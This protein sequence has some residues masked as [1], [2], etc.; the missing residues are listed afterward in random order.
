[1]KDRI[2]LFGI[3]GL[4]WVV[5]FVV[6]RIIFL[7]FHFNLTET[8]SSGEI[9][10]VLFLG[11][12]MDLA[13]AGDWLVLSGI[14][15]M[16]SILITDSNKL[17]YNINNIV[18]ILL[19]IISSLIIVIDLELYRHWG[20][21]LNTT[22]LFYISTEAAGS[23]GAL[24][25]TVLILNFIF[26]TGGFL[27]FYFKKISYRFL[28]LKPVKK[29]WG[30]VMLLLIGSLILPIRSG[31]GV[32]PLNTGMV[33]FHKTKAFPNHAGINVV[34]NFFRS[35]VSKSETRYP[36]NFFDSKKAEENLKQLVRTQ[37]AAPSLLTQEKP[38][39][40]IVVL[41]SFTS[42]IIGPLG[43][44]KDVTPNL[45]A[46]VHEGILFDHFYASGDRTDK[47]IIS[48]LSGYPA[49]PRT[50]IIKYPEKTQSLPYLPKI[51]SKSGYYT[52]FTYGGNIGFANMESY[53]TMAGFNSLTD[54]D[55][56]D[57]KLNSSKW[58]VYDHYVFEHLIH[59]LDTAKTPFF[60][61]L[62]SLSSH[63][64]FDVP[65]DPPFKT[66]NDEMSLFLNA[67]HY[68]DQSLGNFIEQAKTKPW[69]NNTLI[70]I[71]AD[72]GHRLPN[73]Q[74]SSDKERF[75]IPMLW[76]GGAVSKKDTVIHTLS[77]QP[78][79][80]NT[81]LGQFQKTDTTFKFSKNLLAPDAKPFAV[82]VFQNGYGFIDNESE[83]IYD[84]DFNNYIKKESSEE[85]LMLGKAYMQALFSD[86]NNR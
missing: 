85:K 14:F 32:A 61:V 74:E 67:C 48:I 4:Y 51:F 9:L 75:K 66:G 7:L 59:E 45:N 15:L 12:R 78:D 44:I 27:W 35:L 28:D 19:L 72:H 56:F 17:F 34:W 41:E 62:L 49:Q 73:A 83:A 16:L 24:T 57:S 21:R 6:G 76:I 71:T 77:G 13:M 18:T 80:A 81:L 43:G 64:P 23:I 31:F 52:S 29:Q 63:E 55:S 36:S 42:K 69:W 40:I 39:I 25:Y 1:M 65:L 5:F 82:Y 54:D 38:N 70:I 37:Q 22:P 26:L 47:G 30:I 79:I 86:Y 46:L 53:F 2:K 60:S 68:T 84:F 11:L 10:T 20:F 58:G 8:L 3:I 33:Y 50:S